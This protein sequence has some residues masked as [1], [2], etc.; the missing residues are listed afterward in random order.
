MLRKFKAVTL[1]IVILFSISNVAA[2]PVTEPTILNQ[3][4]LDSYYKSYI[5]KIWPTV[6]LTRDVLP[7]DVNFFN[8]EIL[9]QSNIN[10]SLYFK[11]NDSISNYDFFKWYFLLHQD[12]KN[13]FV[14]KRELSKERKLL[15]NSINRFIASKKKIFTL[16]E[17]NADNPLTCEIFKST[18]K[19]EFGRCKTA[20]NRYQSI[21]YIFSKL[22][23]TKKID[24]LYKKYIDYT[25]PQLNT[26]YKSTFQL[27]NHDININNKIIKGLFVNWMTDFRKVN[28]T[29]LKK[30]IAKMKESQISGVSIEVGWDDIEMSKNLLKYPEIIDWV[31]TEL[32]NNGM[33]VI[34]LLSPHYTPDWVFKK[35]PNDIRMVNRDGIP[36]V[37]GEYATYS[38]FSPAVFDQIEFQQKATKHYSSFS[39]IITILLGNEQ[40]YGRLSD[41][42]YSSWAKIAWNDWQETNNLRKTQIPKEKNEKYYYLWK[43]FRQIGLNDYY[44]KVYKN[45]KPFT[46]IPLSF[47]HI[48][49]EN[50]SAYAE[51]YGLNLSPVD[52]KTDV[53]AVDIYGYTPNV[54]ALIKAFNVPKLATETNLPGDWD[55]D[56]FF[57]HLMIN[58]FQG[59]PVQSIFAWIKGEFENALFHNSGNAY[60][61][62]S[63]IKKAARLINLLNMPEIAI[64]DQAIVLPT[65]GL[66]FEGHNYNKYQYQLDNIIDK[67]YSDT[68]SYPVIIWSSDINSDKD[69]LN[70]ATWSKEELSKFNK[71]IHIN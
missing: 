3:S 20:M 64:S 5:S 48:P 49:Y 42:D 9:R 15:I 32:R 35:Y 57:K 63:A 10:D 65:D 59:I 38:F 39:N 60:K 29:D 50:T 1:L 56:K 13:S 6:N 24:V 27:S 61:K 17:E 36:V 54:F 31:I 41:L 14:I 66:N 69:I 23:D 47:K 68:S 62:F 53:L 21:S 67:I 40:S 51:Q 30:E 19:T 52:I 43:R 11:P 33:Y 4:K 8:I 55:E 26:T 71:L 22:L 45:V 46:K 28:K 18:F 37:E 12:D 70:K 7:D 58:Y 2:A 25:Y 34:L 44:N 16:N